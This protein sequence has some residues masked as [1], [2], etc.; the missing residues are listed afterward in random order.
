MLS[1]SPYVSYLSEEKH[2]GEVDLL[3]FIIIILVISAYFFVIPLYL[4]AS[5]LGGLKE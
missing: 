2:Y 5:V 1:Y 4:R 3:L